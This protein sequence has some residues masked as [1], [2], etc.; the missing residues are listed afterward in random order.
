MERN[1]NRYMMS[2]G[3][4]VKTSG[5]EAPPTVREG[6]SFIALKLPNDRQVIL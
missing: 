5:T 3:I 2:P 4:E 6:T 1:R